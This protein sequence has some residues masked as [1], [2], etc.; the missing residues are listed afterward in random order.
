MKNTKKLF[1]IIVILSLVFSISSYAEETRLL[2]EEQG[3]SYKV[4]AAEPRSYLVASR[5]ASIAN[6]EDGTL[7]VYGQIIAHTSLDYACIKLSLERYNPEVDDWLTLSYQEEEF[8]I[9]EEGCDEEFMICP[10]VSYTLS[11]DGLIPGYYYRIRGSYIIKKDGRRET[12]NALT[13]GVLLTD[14]K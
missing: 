9:G 5:I 13:D 3:V 6:N 4:E 8:Y 10:S 11:G 12:A 14:I 1:A 7:D 2:P